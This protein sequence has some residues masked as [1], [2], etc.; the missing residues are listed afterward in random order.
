[1]SRA[2]AQCNDRGVVG[3]SRVAGGVFVR[4]YQPMAI[5]ICVVQGRNGLLLVDTRASPAEAAELR[6]DLQELGAP[7]RW[8]VNTHAHFDHT[9][10]NQRFGPGSAA[11]LSLYGHQRLPAHLDEYER[12]RLA[13]WRAGTGQE[14]HR[15]WDDV[16]ITPPTHLVDH[17]RWLD[18]GGRAVELVPLAPGHTDNDLVLHVPGIDD[19]VEGGVW[20]VGDVLEQPSPPMY[21]SGCFPMSWPDTLAGLLAEVEPGEVIVPGH[22]QPVSRAFGLAQLSELAAVADRIKYHHAA[23][24]S[25]EE[26]LSTQLDWPF[27]VETLALAVSRGYAQLDTT[28][29]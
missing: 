20:I 21:G 22:G 8:V 7:L 18:L 10:G 23:K 25:V 6:T 4:H 5:T 11:N 24:E 26:A 14:P 1:M 19:G 27:P 12:P 9:F 29:S 16:V 15:D 13:A 2:A 3:W 17:R 28:A